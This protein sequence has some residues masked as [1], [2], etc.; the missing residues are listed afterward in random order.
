ML[1]LLILCFAGAVVGTALLVRYGHRH[2]RRYSADVPQ[3][4][5]LG[6]V[7]RAGGMAIWAACSL[8]WGWMALSQRLH[9]A[10]QIRG[11][12]AMVGALWLVASI[13]MA[14]GV[15]EDVRQGLATR[16]RLILTLFAAT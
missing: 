9:W 13:C 5:H 4:F 3:R 12:A 7:P 6:Q 1:F 15:V 2:A 8:G 14:G 11:D 10:N 16:Y